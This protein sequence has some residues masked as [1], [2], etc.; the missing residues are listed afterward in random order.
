MSHDI[1]LQG[2]TSGYSAPGR[3]EKNNV[4]Q[5]RTSIVSVAETLSAHQIDE[6]ETVKGFIAEKDLHGNVEQVP[7][8]EGIIPDDDDVV[9]DP[10][11]K[12]Y[13]I[14]LVARTVD[15]KNDPT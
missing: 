6:L 5:K 1:E 10:R 9:I 15:L 3:D 7:L 2:R 14:P 13:P 4:F 12:D 11:L 8:G